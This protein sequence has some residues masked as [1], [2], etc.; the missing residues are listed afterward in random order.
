MFKHV[1]RDVAFHQYYFAGS[2]VWLRSERIGHSMAE[3]LRSVLCMHC[4]Q[5]VSAFGP[6][7]LAQAKSTATAAGMTV[8][9]IG[10]GKGAGRMMAACLLSRKLLPG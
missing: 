7:H 10:Q 5:G 9:M 1:F 6:S 4:L 2:T 3:R 8:K